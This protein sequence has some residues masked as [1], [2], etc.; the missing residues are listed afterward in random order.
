MD[1]NSKPNL[2]VMLT[3][4]DITVPN[5]LEVFDS[6]RD[7]PV[8]H[9]GFKNVGLPVDQMTALVSQMKAAGKTTYLEV[10]TYDEASCM[11]AAKVAVSCKFDVLMGTLYYDSV[12]QFLKEHG[13]TYSPFVGKVSGSPSILEGTNQEIIDDAKS[14]M[15]KGIDTF[16][17][18]AYRHVVDGE[19][20]AYEFCQA[21]DA[22]ICIAGS[23]A[24][25]QRIDTMFDIKPWA[26]TMGSALF[27]NKFVPDA[28][29]RENL[30]AVAQYMQ[31]HA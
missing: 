8:Q 27:D 12:H 25:Y 13:T 10:V 22:K 24:S 5:A 7:I 16:D 18:L 31:D 2:I 14:M 20:L 29:F 11:K 15:A 4:N 9:W 23:I 3:Y 26:F 6:C 28:G 19:K 21:V 1:M 17:I 30:V